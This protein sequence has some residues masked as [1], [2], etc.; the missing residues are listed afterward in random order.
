V[1]G[2]FRETSLHL[3]WFVA[4]W[5]GCDH[6]RPARERMLWVVAFALAFAVE[7]LLVR[8]FFPGPLS[9]A[10]GIGIILDPRE[11]F[12]SSGFLSLTAIC[13]IGLAV[14]FPLGCLVLLR[15]S[16]RPDWRRRFF[17]LNCYAFPG[18]LVF[19]RMMNGNL[20]E[21]RMLFPVLIPCI[22]GAAYASRWRT[23]TRPV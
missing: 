5:A 4:L 13:S 7:Y 16:S 6:S 23:C 14:L 20:S 10:G 12:F 21:F 11:L 22:Y 9:S 19:Y 18:W 17:E 1:T 8:H 3:V 2:L 15:D